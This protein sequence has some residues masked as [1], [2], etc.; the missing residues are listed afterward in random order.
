ML[1]EGCCLR[2]PYPHEFCSTYHALWEGKNNSSFSP[3]DGFWRSNLK[4]E[5]RET[6]WKKEYS[7]SSFFFLPRESGRKRTMYLTNK[8]RGTLTLICRL[9]GFCS[10]TLWV[11]YV[12][13]QFYETLHADKKIKKRKI[14]QTKIMMVGLNLVSQKLFCDTIIIEIFP[15][16]CNNR[17]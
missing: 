3:W 17:Y 16:N 11:H 9:S 13:R 14:V 12:L 1:N 7:S 15:R 4:S 2:V 6:L 5:R 8:P 10:Y